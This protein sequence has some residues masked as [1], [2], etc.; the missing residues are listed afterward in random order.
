M[1]PA[2]AGTATQRKRGAMAVLGDEHGASHDGEDKVGTAKP[3]LLCKHK[4]HTRTGDMCGG[5]STPQYTT[6]FQVEALGLGQVGQSFP[7]TALEGPHVK[8]SSTF[9]E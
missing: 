2:P 3:P 6:M 7:A 9:Q 8:S 4:T 1:F 5:K